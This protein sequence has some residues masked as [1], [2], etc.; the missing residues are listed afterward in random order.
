M[1]DIRQPNEFEPLYRKGGWD[2]QG[3]G[4]GSTEAFTRGFR[5]VFEKLLADLKITSVFDLG[6]GDWQWQ[7]HVRWDHMRYT[8]WDVSQT[9]LNQA[10]LEFGKTASHNDFRLEIKDAF[11]EP[12]WPKTDLLLVK[13]VVHHLDKK[14]VLK[15]IK[16][17]HHYP[18]V[19]WVVDIE[20]SSEGTRH[21]PCNW[22]IKHGCLIGTKLYEF[23]TSVENYRYGPKAAILQTRA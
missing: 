4:P 20:K 23:D 17:A 7:Q 10:D 5:E 2:G 16:R 21:F 11:I 8:G 9:A 22:P 18:C 12:L 14:A 3:S 1:S 15:L 6:C 13:D 19:L